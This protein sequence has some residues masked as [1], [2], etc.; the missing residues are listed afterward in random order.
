MTGPGL[1]LLGVVATFAFAAHLLLRPHAYLGKGTAPITD[2][3]VIRGFGIFFLLLGG[4]IAILTIYQF[5]QE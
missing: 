2:P 3:R 1:A 5:V 4:S